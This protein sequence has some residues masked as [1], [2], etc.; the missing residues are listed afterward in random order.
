MT[1][2]AIKDLA[3]VLVYNCLEE[4]PT[5]QGGSLITKILRG[6]TRAQLK[7]GSQENYDFS[8]D[9]DD[10]GITLVKHS[11]DKR[12]EKFIGHA[13]LPTADNPKELIDFIKQILVDYFY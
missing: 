4:N 11:Q 13:D 6:I 3:T 9:T 7:Y 5:S 8:I 12:V 1:Q 10:K 2:Q